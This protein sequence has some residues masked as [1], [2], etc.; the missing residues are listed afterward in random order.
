MIII[1]IIMDR[2]FV[3]N[4]ILGDFLRISK[5]YLAEWAKYATFFEKKNQTPEFMK[6]HFYSQTVR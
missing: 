1:I 4:G 3:K 6:S 2:G 5:E